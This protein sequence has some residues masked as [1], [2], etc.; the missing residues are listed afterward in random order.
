MGVAFEVSNSQPRP[1]LYLFLLTDDVDVQLSP[2]SPCLPIQ[3]YLS[4]MMIM[5]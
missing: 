5:D 3:C 2:P 4:A 1:S